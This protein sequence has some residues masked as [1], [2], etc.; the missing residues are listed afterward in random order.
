M[1]AVR[2]PLVD[3]LL[4]HADAAPHKAALNGPDG[5][6]SYGEL[7]RMITVAAARIV[8]VIGR[9]DRVVLCGP[10]SLQLAAAYF[11]VHAAGGVAVLLDADAPA[12]SVSWAVH[13]SGARLVLLG[14]RST[15]FSRNLPVQPPEGDTTSDTAAPQWSLADAT[16]PDG[17]E[18]LGSLRAVFDDPADLVYTTG[19]LGRRKGV[20]LTH[21]NIFQA[22]HNINAFI[23]TTA[24]DR[25][26][27]PLPLSHSFGL[28]R[29]RVMALVGHCL[30]LLPGMRNPAAVLKQLLD[31]QAT[32]LALV[33][34]GVDLVLRMTRDR[35]GDARQHLGYIEIGSAPMPPATRDKL[36]ELLPNTRICHHYGLTEA[37]R[38][39]FLEYHA[40]REHLSSIGRPSPNVEMAVRDEEGRDLPDGQQGQLAVRG[41]M[42]MQ[43][44]WNQPDLTRSVLRIGWLYT[45][46]LGWRDSAGYYHLT[47]RQADVVNVGGRKVSPNEVEEALNAH[48]AVVESA[49]TGVPD[50]QGIVGET[51]KAFIVLRSEVSDE[52]II[53]WLRQ[54][55][56]EYKVPRI[57]QRVDRI[58]KTASGKIQRRLM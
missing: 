9:G 40:D 15:G 58:A 48:P 32:G 30:L 8:R 44:Y 50:P 23:G 41:R 12:E 57:W 7:A 13:D 36:I 24:D 35:L 4:A 28:G 26:V 47:G 27:M 39:A 14:A 25:E 42:V 22:A 52:Q 53:D 51:L 21:E 3:N 2:Q 46:D 10:N 18:P 17:I 5:E 45:G 55:L 37:S 33:P 16:R 19:T 31:A 6:T 34:A 38:A 43:Q 11:A 49:C 1:N 56:E 20:L 54:R 29:L